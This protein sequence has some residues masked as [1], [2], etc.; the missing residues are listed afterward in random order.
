M[1]LVDVSGTYE[2]I[3]LDNFSVIAEDKYPYSIIGFQL[4]NLYDQERIKVKSKYNT[5]DI[6]HILPTANIEA[7]FFRGIKIHI[8]EK[9][10]SLLK[11]LSKFNTILTDTVDVKLY[12]QLLGEY[13]LT[14]EDSYALL[15]KGVYPIDGK[16]LAEISNIDIILDSLYENAFDTKNVPAFQ[17]F[18]YFTIFILC[19]ETIYKR[20]L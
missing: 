15:R 8:R 6:I 1:T 12:K 11:Q 3:K 17:S 14:C 4:K 10:S 2:P 7:A 20:S 16:C 5:K 13:N 18:S 19:N 9:Y